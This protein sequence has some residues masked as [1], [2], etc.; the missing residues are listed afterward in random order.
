MSQRNCLTIKIIFVLILLVKKNLGSPFS[1]V[2]SLVKVQIGYC[3]LEHLG[4]VVF[5]IWEHLHRYREI[6]W[7]WVSPYIPYMQIVLHNILGVPAFLE[8]RCRISQVWPQHH[9]GTKKDLMPSALH[10]HRA[11]PWYTAKHPYKQKKYWKILDEWLHTG[12]HKVV[13]R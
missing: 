9:T 1:S 11:Y 8:V 5:L 6:T 4:P 13:G 12:I 2:F 7:A 3:S 10:M